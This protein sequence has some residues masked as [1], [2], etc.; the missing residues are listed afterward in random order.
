[1]SKTLLAGI[2]IGATNIKYGLVTETGEVVYK[3][4]VVTPDSNPPDKLFEQVQFC[5]EQ[6]LIMADEEN[7]IVP[8]IG[9]GS[10]GTVNI[11]T[12]VIEGTCPNLPGWVG[13]HL[14]ERLKERL[15]LPVFIDN[16]ANCASL[17]EMRF[18]AGI[19]F[20]DI[21]CLTI[22]TGIGGTII[23]KGRIHRGV[24]FAAGEI[25]HMK[26]CNGEGEN[27]DFEFLE[28]L[29]S[30]KAIIAEVEKRL[31]KEM[32]PA[33]QNQ[34]GDNLGRLT[35]RKIFN[36]IKRGD[37]MALEVVHQK[38]H[39]LGIALSGLVNVL[40]PE[41]IVL[42]GGVA[43]GGKMFVEKVSATIKAY[44]LPKASENLRILTAILGNDAGFIGAALLGGADKIV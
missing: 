41:L 22:G 40:N 37:K 30:S 32:T 13:F 24:S 11:E 36:A 17:A 38:G 1:M 21:I 4:K 3:S 42:G 16:D 10:P 26:V 9:V 6:L 39:L 15:N 19:G 2:D 25:G 5:G 28:K 35:I 7:G 14:R 12:G 18:G 44:S 27:T 33:F 29:V 8:N 20:E 31:E 23:I 43:E 34:I